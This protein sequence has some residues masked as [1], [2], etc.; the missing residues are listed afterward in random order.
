MVCRSIRPM[1]WSRRENQPR[2]G[3]FKQEGLSVWHN[4]R[5]LERDVRLEDLLIENLVGFGQAHHRAGDCTDLARE[6][7]EK[8]G[9]PFE[10]QVEWRPED[11][12]VEPPWRQW[13]YAHVQV[14][15]IAGPAQFLRRFRKLLTVNSRVVIPPD[16]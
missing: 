12:Y 1:H 4:G 3:A 6:V 7:S 14:E 2:E 5:L 16:L 10:V 15:A 11:E 8:S 9:E 13:R